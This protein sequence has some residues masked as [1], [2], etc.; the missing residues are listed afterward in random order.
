MKL[1]KLIDRIQNLYSK[2]VKSDDSLLSPIYIYNVLTSIRNKLIYEE[3]TKKQRINQWNYQTLS[4]VELIEVAPH[5]CDCLP[6]GC[7]ILRTKYKL[8]KPINDFNTHLIQSVTS[9]DGSLIYYETTWE[10]LLFEKG[11]RYVKQMAGYYIRNEYLYTR[12]NKGQELISITGLFEDPVEAAQYPSACGKK[13]DCVD[14]V[15]C[16]DFFEMDFPIDGKYIETIVQISFN[17]LINI[18]NS[19]KNDITNNS[20]DDTQQN[21]K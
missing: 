13:D 19:S 4:C 3:A 17:E 18:F 5:E 8:P 1:G 21:T 11:N 2:G 14:C 15:E 6:S 12:Y 16:P 20:I 10:N 7:K 9:I